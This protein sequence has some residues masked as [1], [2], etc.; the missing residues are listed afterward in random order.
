MH[1]GSRPKVAMDIEPLSIT[2]I[3]F[4]LELGLL[5]ASKAGV[6]E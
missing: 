1:T 6:R 3:T 4:D 2:Q 5:C